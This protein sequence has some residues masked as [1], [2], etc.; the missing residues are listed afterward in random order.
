MKEVF[1]EKKHEVDGETIVIR[2]LSLY[3]VMVEVPQIIGRII[4]KLGDDIS[5][6]NITQKCPGEALALLSSVTGKEKNFWKKVPLD[7]GTEIITDFLEMTLTE[8]FFKVL[9]RLIQAGRKIG[10]VLSSSSLK[11]D[12]GL[13]KSKTIQGSN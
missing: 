8:N 5:V 3:E 13:K 4:D 6:L 2:P 11:M 12:T 10:S 1:P 9:P 7:V